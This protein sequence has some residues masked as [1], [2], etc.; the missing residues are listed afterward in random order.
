MKAFFG[1]LYED[2][3]K[4]NILHW[5]SRSHWSSKT[6][7][8]ISGLVALHCS[9]FPWSSDLGVYV[10][11]EVDSSPD[12]VEV[13]KIE[14]I[15]LLKSFKWEIRQ[16]KHFEIN[17]RSPNK[18]FTQ[19]QLVRKKLDFCVQFPKIVRRFEIMTVS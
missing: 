1:W 3:T 2:K 15:K 16:D 8:C 10:M 13:C 11:V 18:D 4:Q 12:T 19:V 17:L 6:P 5:T 9:V 7:R 14:S